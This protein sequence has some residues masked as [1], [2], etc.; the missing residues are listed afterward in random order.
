MNLAAWNT[1]IW[2]AK[3]YNIIYQYNDPRYAASTGLDISKDTAYIGIG[4]ALMYLYLKP[5][6]T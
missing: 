6:G 1:K 3:N 5:I 4:R 2:D